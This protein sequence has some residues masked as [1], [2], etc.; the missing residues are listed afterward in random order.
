MTFNLLKSRDL[1]RG[2]CLAHSGQLMFVKWKGQGVVWV[3]GE[4]SCTYHAFTYAVPPPGDTLPD[5][6]SPHSTP[7]TSL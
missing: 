7:I 6:C 1:N 5:L 4:G 3:H 2:Q